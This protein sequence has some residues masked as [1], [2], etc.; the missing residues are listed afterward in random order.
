MFRNS[1]LAQSCI[2]AGI[3]INSLTMPPVRSS[4][5]TLLYPAL[6]SATVQTSTSVISSGS[7]CSLLSTSR[8]QRRY[9]HGTS[10]D[11]QMTVVTDISRSSD[12]LHVIHHH[13]MSPSY[14]LQRFRRN[15]TESEVRTRRHSAAHFRAASTG[16]SRQRRLSHDARDD[17]RDLLQSLHT[18]ASRRRASSSASCSHG[19]INL[20]SSTDKNNSSQQ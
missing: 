2:T 11:S 8:I 14:T 20:A 6:S 12:Q 5:Q 1:N 15:S 10:R 13:Q 3:N 16:M 19:S 7:P 4:L 18:V 17:P 9:S